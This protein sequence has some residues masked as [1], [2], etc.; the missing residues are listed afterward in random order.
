MVDVIIPAYNNRDGLFRA[1]SSLVAQTKSGKCIV[2]VV[3]DCSTEDLKSVCEIFKP[4]LKI[5]YVRNEENLRYP[6]LVR[7]V[8]LEKTNAPYVMFLDNDDF[9]APEAIESAQRG[10]M[11]SGADVIIGNFM[12]EDKNGVF[13]LMDQSQTTW[14]HGNVYKREYLEKNAIHFPHG[15]NEDGGFNT[16]CYLLTDKISVIQKPMYYWMFNHESLT[17]DQN[18][19]GSFSAVHCD[20]IVSTL[21]DAYVNIFTHEVASEKSIVN[22][23]K[24]I[25]LFHMLFNNLAVLQDPAL[26]EK[27]EKIMWTSLLEFN[28][29]IKMK[30]MIENPTILKWLKNG[31]IEGYMIYA[32]QYNRVSLEEFLKKYMDLPIEITVEDFMNKGVK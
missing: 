7:Q 5:N 13:K 1:L 26:I 18:G 10:M 14:L 16:Q 17:R 6:G 15:F 9:L 27:Y 25:G 12:S 30:Q 23:G 31:I 8:G 20:D 24:H 28:D 22:L 29:A 3:D 2:T 32:K 4:Y 21:T 11:E 19:E